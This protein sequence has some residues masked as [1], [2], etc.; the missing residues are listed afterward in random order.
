MMTRTLSIAGTFELSREP[1][2]SAVVTE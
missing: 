2:T 1:K